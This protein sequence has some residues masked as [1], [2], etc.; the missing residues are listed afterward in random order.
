MWDGEQL[1]GEDSNLGSYYNQNSM[2]YFKA[3]VKLDL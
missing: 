2:E 1:P 3:M